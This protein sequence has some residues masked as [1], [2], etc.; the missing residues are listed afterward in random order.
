VVDVAA[1]LAILCLSGGW[2]VKISIFEPNQVKEC[3]DRL[4]SQNSLISWMWWAICV[5][6]ALSLRRTS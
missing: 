3:A 4:F 1:A 2:S 5:G 6:N